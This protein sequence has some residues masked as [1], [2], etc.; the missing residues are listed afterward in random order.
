MTPYV[1]LI[2]L[3]GTI[4][5]NVSCLVGEWLLLQEKDKRK[6]R[7]YKNFVL[8]QLQ[9]GII[10]PNFADFCAM[11]SKHLS[12]VEYFVY[13]ASGTSWANF[14][15]PC[16]EEVCGIRF[17]RPI[18]T[19]KFCILKNGDYRKS[20]EDVLPEILKRLKKQYPDLKNIS[21]LQDMVCLIDNNEVLGKNEK[22]KLIKCPTY[23]FIDYY[24]VFTRF[25][26]DL[27]EKDT[28]C[29]SVAKNLM[30]YGLF[31]NSSKSNI[32]RNVFKYQYYYQLC[33]NIKN[34]ILH[35]QSNVNSSPTTDK[36]W[37]IL[38]HIITHMSSSLK[39]DKRTIQKIQMR[40]NHECAK[41]EVN[42]FTKK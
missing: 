40:L 34:A 16:I 9:N 18:F 6:I 17:Q 37:L 41:Y 13:T 10:R 11:T 23:D 35:E 14:L 28:D 39:F 24:D 1:V 27:I 22:H 31:P 20:I 25:N 5:G 7:L 26:I 19:R 42:D 38:A 29:T 12:N 3:D 36:F 30:Q 4:V 15:I 8:K 33:Q 2:D 32:P 21:Q